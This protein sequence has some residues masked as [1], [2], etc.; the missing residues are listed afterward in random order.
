[1]IVLKELT[2]DELE[3]LEDRN[4]LKLPVWASAKTTNY[5]EKRKILSVW[6]GHKL[7]AIYTIPLMKDNNRI[8]VDRKFRFFPYVSPIIFEND[9]IKRREIVTIL[10]KY[11]VDNYDVLSIPLSPEFKDIAPIQALGIFVECWHTHT[12]KSELTIEKMPSRLKNHIKN[13]EKQIKIVVDTKFEN[14]NFEKAIKG[15]T[16]EINIRKESAINIIK[17][18]KGFLVTGID[19]ETGEKMGAIMIAYDRR[20]AYLLHSWRDKNA[21]RGT[22]PLLIKTATEICFKEKEIK[23]FDFEGAVIQNIDIFFSGFNAQITTYPYLYW[24]KDKSE[25][26]K[27]IDDSINIDGRLI[28]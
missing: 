26:I 3:K 10:F 1:M 20:W 23:V 28:D 11:I 24:A 19:K 12:L 22:I 2:T 27:L 13:A 17:Q 5:Y 6:K 16:N 14:Y 8:I 15:P 4:D 21:P 7:E 9:N 18:K 25:Y